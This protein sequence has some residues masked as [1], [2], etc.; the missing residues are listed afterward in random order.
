MAADPGLYVTGEFRRNFDVLEKSLLDM[1]AYLGGTPKGRSRW[2]AI[3]SGDQSA[4]SRSVAVIA[5]AAPARE[6]EITKEEQDDRFVAS[7]KPTWLWAL[8]PRSAI[9]QHYTNPVSYLCR[10]WFA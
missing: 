4:S 3:C 5:G 2:P 10:W 7:E 9:P 8:R 1:R 6:H